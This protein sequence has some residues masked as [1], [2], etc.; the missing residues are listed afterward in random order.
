ME[1]NSQVALLILPPAKD[2]LP[3]IGFI[4]WMTGCLLQAGQS[5]E[6]VWTFRIR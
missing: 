1:V 3:S 2:T 4:R 6:S 5:P